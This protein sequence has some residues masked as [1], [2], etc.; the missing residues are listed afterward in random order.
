MKFLSATGFRRNGTTAALETR[1]SCTMK[2]S[3]DVFIVFVIGGAADV[4]PVRA[5]A[6]P[7]SIT[8]N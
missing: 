6:A 2:H 5:D 1:D 3:G 8:R 7:S 4:L